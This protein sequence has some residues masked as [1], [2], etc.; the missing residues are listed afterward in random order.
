MT[1]QIHDNSL[2]EVMGHGAQGTGHGAQG[3]GTGT[4]HRARGTGTGHGAQGTGHRAR[5]KKVLLIQPFNAFKASIA[6]S[7]KH[8]S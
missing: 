3:T 1:V 5:G 4:G 7:K 6:L 2:V 8:Q